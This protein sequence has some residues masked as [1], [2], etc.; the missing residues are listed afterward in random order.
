MWCDP[1]DAFDYGEGQKG[2]I[3]VPIPFLWYSGWGPICYLF[4]VFSE[5]L[6]RM[7]VHNLTMEG[8]FS[9]HGKSFAF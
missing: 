9:C 7:D 4:F 1:Q 8:G 5:G 6:A 2:A 3:T